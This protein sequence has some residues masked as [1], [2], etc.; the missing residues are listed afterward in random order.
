MA[1]PTSSRQDYT[2]GL[3]LGKFLLSKE[4]T[5]ENGLQALTRTSMIS[6]VSGL[7]LLSSAFCAVSS[8][9]RGCI[10]GPAAHRVHTSMLSATPY[11]APKHGVFERAD[12]LQGMHMATGRKRSMLSLSKERPGF[13]APPRPRAMP[14]LGWR[15]QRT[16]ARQDVLRQEAAA[17]Q[18]DRRRQEVADGAPLA[19][20]RHRLTCASEHASSLSP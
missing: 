3:Q 15:A 16:V 2:P 20:A 4:T 11:Q 8:R 18:G 13:D 6:W 9:G 7:M 12:H 1:P 17:Q 5:D 10:S 14:P 19:A